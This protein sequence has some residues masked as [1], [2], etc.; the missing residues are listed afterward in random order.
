MGKKLSPLYAETR[1]LL[2]LWALDTSEYVPKSKFVATGK[3][4]SEA[5][6]Q[7]EKSEALSS[8][9]KTKRTKVYSL[10]TAGKQQ[11]SQTLNNDE[12]TFTTSIGPKVTN[13]LLKWFRQ[14]EVV[15]AAKANGNASSNGKAKDIS[16][17]EAFTEVVLKTY[18]KLNQDY[19]L[20][21]L[22]P[23]Y[24]LRREIGDQ[25]SRSKFNEWLLDVQANDLV[26]L[27]GGEMPNITQDQR[28][29]SLSIPGGGMRF[30]AKRL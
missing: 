7:L 3:A 25:V 8:Q 20:D 5:I 12:F 13:A 17:S 26:Q 24:R 28:E 21:D 30:Y 6:A 9:Q 22:V 15:K 27:T 2:G 16:S 1:I 11:L 18:D 29:D 14:H 23:I 19:N 4:Y 10:T